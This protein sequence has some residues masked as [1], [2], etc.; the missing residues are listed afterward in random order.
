MLSDA[1]HFAISL[2]LKGKEGNE[3]LP[4]FESLVEDE[5]GVDDELI[6]LASNI[7]KG[8]LGCTKLFT[9]I[10]KEILEKENTQHGFFDPRFY[11]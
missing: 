8:G 1:L 6:L 4:P 2:N 3:L 11:I 7:K 10:H 5:F 9:F